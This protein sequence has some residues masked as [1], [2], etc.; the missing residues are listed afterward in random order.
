MRIGS[1]NVS[2]KYL[3]FFIYTI[4]GKT[5]MTSE[6]TLY[7]IQHSHE[8]ENEFAGLYI[9]VSGDKVIASGKT[10]HEVYEATDKM[11]VKDPLITYVPRA[12][13]EM[14]LV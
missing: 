7:L 6:E 13:E 5:K 14:L 4:F 3:L 12:G 1:K 2:V 9:A 8:I 11:G 10:I